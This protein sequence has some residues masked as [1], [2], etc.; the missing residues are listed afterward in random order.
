MYRT[1]TTY[2]TEYSTNV[3]DDDDDHD[4]DK[5]TTM[6]ITKNCNVYRYD[7]DRESLQDF[8]DIAS[9]TN[10]SEAWALRTKGTEILY[11]FV[12]KV[13]CRII[14]LVYKEESGEDG[15]TMK[16]RK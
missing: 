1:F 15:I 10:M 7:S 14:G 8:I 16:L 13:H 3:E 4:D 11:G 2:I 9:L 12:R 6:A 5:T